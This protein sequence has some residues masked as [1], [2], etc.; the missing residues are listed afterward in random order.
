MENEA[1]GNE[2]GDDRLDPEKQLLLGNQAAARAVD[3][4]V[5]PW[6]IYLLSCALWSVTFAVAM[7]TGHLWVFSLAL[8]LGVPLANWLRAQ[9][10]GVRLSDRLRWNGMDVHTGGWILSALGFTVVMMLLG[11]V[12]EGLYEWRWATW[13]TGALIGLF[14]AVAEWPVDLR[15]RKTLQGWS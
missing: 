3:H 8:L 5:A 14:W 13:V 2:R 4:I 1:L 6:W 7:G 12:L 15:V 11:N 10:T 9:T